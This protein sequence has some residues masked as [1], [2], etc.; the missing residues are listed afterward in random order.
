VRGESLRKIGGAGQD[1]LWSLKVIFAISMER[2]QLSNP[3]VIGCVVQLRQTAGKMGRKFL[4]VIS[5]VGILYAV[6]AAT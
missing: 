2:R 3:I 5:Q 1:L 6:Q 4:K